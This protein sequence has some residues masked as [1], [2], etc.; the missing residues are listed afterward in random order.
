MYVTLKIA[1]TKH[2]RAYCVESS[3]FRSSNLEVSDT[4]YEHV[5]GRHISKQFGVTAAQRTALSVRQCKI[6]HHF[7]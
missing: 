4:V 6:I 5:P 3:V 7:V 1:D 2:L